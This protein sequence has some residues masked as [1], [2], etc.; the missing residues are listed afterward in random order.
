MGDVGR[1]KSIKLSKQEK[2][3]AVKIRKHRRE[4]QA[5]GEENTS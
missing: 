5:L 2:E 1:G 4:A 3:I